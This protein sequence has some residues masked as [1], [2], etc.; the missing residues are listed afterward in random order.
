MGQ[1]HNS[2]MTTRVMFDEKGDN[3]LVLSG[4]YLPEE[5]LAEIL[6][7]VD[8]KSLLNCQLVCKRW[9]ILIQTYIWRKK[10]E[11]SLRRSLLFDKEVSWDVYYLIC[12]K[13]PF[14]RNLVKNHSGKYGKNRHWKIVTEGGDNWKVEHPPQGVPPLPHEPDEA[15]FEQFCFVT[16]YHR[17]TKVQI[18]D[19][20]SE[21]LTPYVLD[22]LQPPIVV[23]EWYSCR[24]DC[25]AVYECTIKL[26]GENNRTIDFFDFRDD[27]EG[28]K[29]NQ[30]HCMSHQFENYGPGLRQISFYH[31]GIDKLF[32][33]GHYGSKMAGACVRVKIP[34]VQFSDTEEDLIA[35]DTDE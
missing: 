23:S 8:Y 15:L 6:C 29:Q 13:K 22:N 35:P 28:E 25:P 33:A 9:K 31:G 11:I 7:L 32:W 12:K 1:L 26:L 27:I 16:S 19:L 18:I 4:K 34:T 21:G 10:A 30:W 14:E 24:W 17:C 3:G 2:T 5:L 20:E